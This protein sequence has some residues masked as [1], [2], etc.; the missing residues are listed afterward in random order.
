[1]EEK[2]RVYY[3]D[4]LRVIAAVSVVYMHAVSSLLRG[5][6]EINWHLSNLFTSFA[7]TAV[8]LF[9]MMSGYLLLS[10]EKT[11]DVSVLLR[12]RLPRL[13]F[14]LVGW[15]IVVVLYQM[16]VAQ[17]YTLRA[18]YDGLV[19]ALTTPAQISYWYMY[20]LIAIYAISPVLAGGLRVLDEKGHRYV[21]VLA[22]LASLR[23][24][25]KAV[26]PDG[27][28]HLLNVDILDKLTFFSGNLSTFVLGYYLGNLKKRIPNG[29]LLS[30]AAVV[31]AIIV[32]GTTVLTRKSGTYDATFQSQGAG[33]EVLLAGLVFLLF[34]QN[35]NKPSRLLERVPLVPLSLAM[36][37]MHAV[38]LSM[39]YRVGFTIG[40][41]LDAVVVTL[42]NMTVCFFTMKTVA[43]I[44]PICYLATGMP[45]RV[46]CDRCNWVYT[47]RW[48][49]AWMGKRRGAVP[50]S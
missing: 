36:Y 30:G 1:M 9:F 7:F 47:F 35:A 27:A 45:Y 24:M 40:S 43:T 38:L 12:K 37:M 6:I 16:Y 2:R 15:S 41:F 17:T 48:I 39:M 4:Y 31:L 18:L 13:I 28:D 49:R 26:T 5:P 8:P 42:I 44:K 19:S 21:V 10:E 25:L 33:F 3:F 34:K 11:M 23:A 46:A 14:P 29:I 22:S 20:T 50:E 32:A